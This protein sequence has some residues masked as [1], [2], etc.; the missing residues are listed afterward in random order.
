MKSSD[1]IVGLKHIANQYS[2]IALIWHVLL[3]AL[4]IAL[5]L[6]WEPS[7]KLFSLIL[8]LPIL[9][10]AVLAWINGN[11][12]NGTTFSVLAILLSIF[13]FR[14]SNQPVNTAGILFSAIGILMVAY[15]LV[16]PHFTETSSVIEYLYK[17]PVGLVPCPTLSVV[18]GFVLLFNGFGSQGINYVLILF[19]LFYGLFGFFKLGVHLDIGLIIGSV[20][21]LIKSIPIFKIF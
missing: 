3:F 5:F 2:F 4:I 21:L 7:N 20:V 6:K 15:G 13:A 12:F 17:A 11:P 18:I 9:S 16:Y 8:I 14:T 19:G 1:I 10:I